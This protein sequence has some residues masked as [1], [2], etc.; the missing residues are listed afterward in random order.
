MAL[1]GLE[2]DLLTFCPRFWQG[3]NIA[4]WEA[5]WPDVE[6]GFELVWK[7]VLP[8]AEIG[9]DLAWELAIWPETGDRVWETDLLTFARDSDEGATLPCWRIGLPGEET[10]FESVWKVVLPD[11]EIG[12][13]LV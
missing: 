7:V 5:V 1:P 13:E 9:F 2:N 6:I 8:D 10:G 12:F 4:L 11:V 3:D